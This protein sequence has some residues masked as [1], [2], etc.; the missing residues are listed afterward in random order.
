TSQPSTAAFHHGGPEMAPTPP[1]VRSAPAQPGRSSKPP[2]FG[3]P[4]HSRVAPLSSLGGPE[5]AP[6]PPTFGAP[7]RSRVAPLSSLGAPKWPPNPQRSERPGEA[8]SL[9]YPTPQRPSSPGTRDAP[10][11][12]PRLSSWPRGRPRVGPPPPP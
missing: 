2:T 7:R 5:M 1:S 6:K 11:F 9:L 4:R 8:V 12:P 3:A 10:R